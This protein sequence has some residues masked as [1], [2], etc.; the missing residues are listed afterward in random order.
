MLDENSY[1]FFFVPFIFLTCLCHASHIFPDFHV[2]PANTCAISALF[3]YSYCSL[4][5]HSVCVSVSV[6]FFRRVVSSSAFIAIIVLSFDV[7]SLMF[8]YFYT[9][10][11]TFENKSHVIRTPMHYSL[12]SVQKTCPLR[13]KKVGVLFFFFVTHSINNFV[14]MQRETILRHRDN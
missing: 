9:S 4:L 11:H 10:F 1:P 8:I 6:H 7:V 14:G 3:F 5:F 13:S 12:I 2:P